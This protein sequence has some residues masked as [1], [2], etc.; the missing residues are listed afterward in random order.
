MENETTYYLQIGYRSSKEIVLACWDMDVMEIEDVQ[1]I[2]DC[3]TYDAYHTL[4]LF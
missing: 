4:G 1:R 2:R 3:G